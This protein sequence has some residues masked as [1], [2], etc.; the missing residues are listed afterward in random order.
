MIKLNK[1]RVTNEEFIIINVNR[2]DVAIIKADGGSEVKI[3]R[4]VSEVEQ[5]SIDSVLNKIQYFYSIGEEY[6]KE[7]LE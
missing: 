5:R 3:I 1:V 6:V 4:E 2:R 7:V